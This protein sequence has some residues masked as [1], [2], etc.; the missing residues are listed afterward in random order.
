MAKNP[1]AVP[2]IQDLC[3][4]RVHKPKY[5]NSFAGARVAQAFP[6]ILN[7]TG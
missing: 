1:T 7:A 4:M 3:L 5:N 2:A 6:G